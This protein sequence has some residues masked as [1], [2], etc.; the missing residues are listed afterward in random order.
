MADNSAKCRLHRP[1][2]K[3][4]TAIYRN[5]CVDNYSS[6]APSLHSNV[7]IAASNVH[8]TNYDLLTVPFQLTDKDRKAVIVTDLQHKKFDSSNPFIHRTTPT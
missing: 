8:I 1:V 7:N 6:L 3:P 2:F 5:L 4:A